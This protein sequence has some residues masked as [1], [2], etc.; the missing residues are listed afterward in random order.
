[1]STGYSDFFSSGLLAPPVPYTRPR[2]DSTSSTM[3]TMS[4][5]SN[6]TVTTTIS[7][8]LDD[9]SDIEDNVFSSNRARGTTPTPA[10][11]PPKSPKRTLRKRK[12]SLSV[13]TSPLTSLRSP[14]RAAENAL[15]FQRHLQ[16]TPSRARSG[17]INSVA[18]ESTSMLGRISST[19]G[20][21]PRSG[22]LGTALRSRQRSIR[23]L[24]NNPLPPPTAPLP[25]LPPLPSN[26]TTPQRLHGRSF[27]LGPRAA[28]GS[29]CLQQRLPTVPGTPPSASKMDISD[30]YV[31]PSPRTPLGEIQRGY[32]RMD[33]D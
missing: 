4:T 13:S 21:R 3:S 31:P 24:P 12:S 2:Y 20:G 18:T 11:Q 10:N 15:S 30:V 25:P 7:D 32:G 23:S 19:V 14:N 17:S 29:L 28:G 5:I 22:S 27:S 16:G 8:A 26:P 6:S 1:M 33:E 9:A